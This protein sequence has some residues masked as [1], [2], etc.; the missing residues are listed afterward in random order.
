MSL[1]VTVHMIEALCNWNLSRTEG[2][3]MLANG[4]I[5]NVNGAQFI[6]CYIC[7]QFK[8]FNS[9]E[10]PPICI[11]SLPVL[12]GFSSLY[13]S[14]THTNTSSLTLLL[15]SIE[16]KSDYSSRVCVRAVLL[17]SSLKIK[18]LL[19]L[20]VEWNHNGTINA[21]LVIN[22][23]VFVF[24]QLCLTGYP[25]TRCRWTVQHGEIVCRVTGNGSQGNEV[26]K[27]SISALDCFV[28]RHLNSIYSF[29][30]FLFVFFPLSLFASSFFQ[31]FLEILKSTEVTGE[32]ITYWRANGRWDIPHGS[33]HS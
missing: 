9:M 22:R 2:C 8:Q 25:N 6:D 3:V 24:I 10:N 28:E 1:H 7:M 33:G 23:W 21:N 27:F 4:S 17:K 20:C 13:L 14:R 32:C 31:F 16:Y 29:F 5:S 12:M 19:Y 15:L 26:F 11:Q 18:L 30:S